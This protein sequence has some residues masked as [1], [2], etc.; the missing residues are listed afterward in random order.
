MSA[1]GTI[2]DYGCG[3][4]AL[5]E[6]LPDGSYYLGYDISEEMV[7]AARARYPGVRFTSSE[8]DLQCVDYVIASGIFNVKAGTEEARWVEYV[9]ATL[10]RFDSLGAKGFAFNMLTSYSDPPLMRPELYYADPL[11]W[12]DECKRRYARNVALLH[13]YGLWEF[14]IIVRKDLE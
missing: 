12:F 4:G 3:Y 11:R 7:H 1:A 6:H 2:L 5:T 14:T 8:G 13:D 10:E 9:T